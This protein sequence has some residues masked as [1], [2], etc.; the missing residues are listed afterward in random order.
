MWRA[1][2]R[3]GSET[4]LVSASLRLRLLWRRKSDMIA[5]IQ[6]RSGLGMFVTSSRVPDGTLWC[7]MNM[8]L[9]VIDSWS[10]VMRDQVTLACL[11]PGCDDNGPQ[12]LPEHTGPHTSTGSHFLHK[13]PFR[14][15][16]CQ[17]F[18]AYHSARWQLLHV[19][20]IANK[21]FS[22]AASLID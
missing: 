6:M 5:G 9:I 22:T 21:M 15:R 18:T 14:I 2:R 12:S 11:C 8:L 1:E 7:L 3:I 4:N 20:L 10:Q 17:L 13:V 19:I 16:W